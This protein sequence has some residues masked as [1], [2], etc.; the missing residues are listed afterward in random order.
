MAQKNIVLWFV[1]ICLNNFCLGNN[2]DS[3]YHNVS[4]LLK[5]NRDSALSLIYDYEVKID[6]AAEADKL[7]FYHKASLFFK[8]IGDFKSEVDYLTKKASILPQQSD[9]LHATLL[10]IGFAQMNMG[11]LNGAWESFQKCKSFYS[12]HTNPDQ[13]KLASLYAGMASVLGDRGESEQAIGYFLQAIEINESINNVKSLSRNYSSMALTYL[14]MDAKDKALEASRKAHQYAQLSE[15]GI[16]IH[17]TGLRLGEAL[18]LNDQMDSVLYYF[19]QAEHFFEMQGHQAILN[20]V[21]SNLGEY[22]ARTAAYDKAEAY[23]LKAANIAREMH[24]G[25]LLAST[26]GNYGRV[27]YYLEKYEQGIEVGREAYQIAGQIQ[28]TEIERQVAEAL[29][30]N[31]KG[32]GQFDSALYYYET[33]KV[34]GDSITNMTRQKAVIRKELESTHQKEKAG[35]ISEAELKIE[36]ESQLKL[37]W[38][39]G[40]LMLLIVSAALYWAFQQKKKSSQAILKEKEYLDNLLHNFVHEFRT[41][42]T[43]IKGPTEELLKKDQTNDLLNMV[44]KNSEQMLLLVNQILDF[45]KIKAGKLQVRADIVNLPLFYNGIIDQFSRI[46]TKKQIKLQTDYAGTST[47]KA[48][49]DKIFKIVSNLLSNAI[50]YSDESATVTLQS[51]VKGDQLMISVI[52]TGI[53]IAKS[54]QSKVFTKFYQVDAT[55][56]RKGEGTGLGLTFVRELV[57]LMQ[58]DIQ[59]QSEP[60]K[61]TRVDVNLP[62]EIINSVKVDI[63]NTSDESLLPEQNGIETLDRHQQNVLVIEDNDDMRAFITH[64]LEDRNYKVYE[65][66]NGKFG[67][68]LAIE[69]VPDLIISDVMMPVMDGY[70]VVQALKS[71]LVTDHIPI[72]ML[73]A[74]AS[75]DSMIDGLQLG[76]DD[77]ISKPFKSEEFLLRIGNALER[78]EKLRQKFTDSASS[79]HE[80]EAVKPE[81]VQKIEDI[82]IG[83]LLTH[84]SVEE[85]AEECAMSRSQLHR[86]VKSLTG[87]STTE[88]LTKIR[89]DLAINDIRTTTLSVSEIA[90]KYGY[91]DPAYFSRLFKKQFDLT[92]SEV[93][94]NGT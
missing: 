70:Q 8:S 61:G 43:L 89:L 40:F 84:I 50:K 59:L 82:I 28:Y 45:A 6:Q 66:V 62:V 44:N 49:D 41:P 9:T 92:P 60:G 21:Y 48:D 15:S 65:A 58:G 90:Y 19:K 14:V 32:A 35:I 26:L 80:V 69:I 33:F 2:V 17:Y 11:D 34:L 27:L 22:Y 10:T 87:L 76:V 39:M 37:Y 24:A 74:K 25:V 23:F 31:F 51:R 47:I 3:L 13:S 18:A 91:S 36:R 81:I 5:E 38:L 12:D 71:N 20:S 64:L 88:L 57:T 7:D 67:I 53:G 16:D 52:D 56:T 30:M 54:E 68:D 73:T 79:N 46:A 55:L 4:R 93:R 72:V 42:L 78:Q 63:S 83:D 77:Y 75:F 94:K 86:K 29:Y 85:L 1:L